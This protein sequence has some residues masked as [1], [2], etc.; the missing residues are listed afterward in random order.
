MSNQNANDLQVDSRVQS[1]EKNPKK[2]GSKK[3]SKY[4][5]KIVE[6]VQQRRLSEELQFQQNMKFFC[7]RI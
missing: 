7:S 2:S 3:W 6:R 1:M 4:N 5:V